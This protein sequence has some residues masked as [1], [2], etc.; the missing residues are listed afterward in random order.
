MTIS[1]LKKSIWASIFG[2]CVPLTVLI[3]GMKHSFAQRDAQPK[4]EAQINFFLSRPMTIEIKM[5]QQ[6]RRAKATDILFTGFRLQLLICKANDSRIHMIISF[7]CPILWLKP[8]SQ[9]FTISRTA[10]CIEVLVLAFLMQPSYKLPHIFFRLTSVLSMAWS[11]GAEVGCRREMALALV[12]RS[13]ES[14][15]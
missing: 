5:C 6:I 11:A 2:M 8:C 14:P 1:L 9:L 12:A 15:S 3:F 7:P 13:H 10:Q 4:I